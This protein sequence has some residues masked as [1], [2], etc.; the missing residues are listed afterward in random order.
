MMAKPSNLATLHA[1]Y[2]DL[3]DVSLIASPQDDSSSLEG[4]NEETTMSSSRIL[5]P[6]N[7]TIDISGTPVLAPNK[8]EEPTT[9]TAATPFRDHTIKRWTTHRPFIPEI[10]PSLTIAS[11]NLPPRELYT[12]HLTPYGAPIHP[13]DH[14]KYLRIC[15]QNTQH[16]FRIWGETFSTQ[17]IISNLHLY[18]VDMFAA[19]SPNINWRNHSNWVRTKQVFRP[20]SPR[21]HLLATSS[22]IGDDPSYLS[23]AIILTFG[24]WASKVSKV[25]YDPSGMGIF[26][27]TTLLGKNHKKVT[28][29]LACIS[30]QKSGHVGADT[31]HA[32]QKTIYEKSCLASKRP[33]QP[34]LCPRKHAIITLQAYI[35]SLQKQDHAIIL[36]V[37][38]NQAS[39]ECYS[40]TDVRPY[41][42][43][44]LKIQCNLSDPF[45]D[46]VGKRPSSTTQIPNRDIDYILTWNISPSH[47]STLELNTPA[48]SD[49]LGLILDFELGSYFNASYSAPA[50]LP[51]RSLTSGNKKAV[52]LYFWSMYWID[53]ESTK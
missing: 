23:Q 3:L 1:K 8:T 40:S 24:L 52:D 16:S 28:C 31:V 18:E 44:W 34:N 12:K 38:A 21:I 25:H 7:H 2:C 48:L 15:A 30:V 35:E 9:E 6:R 47:I 46:L 22:E 26:T 4:V 27:S 42:I 43:E 20:R 29:I 10:Q 51:I 32:Q 50:P 14:T 41:T 19:I 39:H 13:V 5:H 33:I 17:T 53:S 49:H 11:D 36:M 45:I 37:D